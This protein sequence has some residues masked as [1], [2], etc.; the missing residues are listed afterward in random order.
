MK[1]N[2]KVLID[3]H[4][5]NS[6]NI[7]LPLW[8]ER[9]KNGDSFS[10]LQPLS[11]SRSRSLSVSSHLI[12]DKYPNIQSRGKKYCVT[13]CKINMRYVNLEYS[14]CCIL[15]HYLLVFSHFFFEQEISFIIFSF[16]SL[17]TFIVSQISK[18]LRNPP[19]YWTVNDVYRGLRTTS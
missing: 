17:T 19:S 13:Y 18:K 11:N 7:H 5:N 4:H 2:S 6:T 12:R 1:L 16:I 10:I 14:F 9:M 3:E 15:I 8:E